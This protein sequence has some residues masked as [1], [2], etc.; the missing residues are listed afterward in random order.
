MSRTPHTLSGR[1][2]RCAARSAPCTLSA[3]LEEEWLAD[4]HERTSGQSR[5]RFAL[6]C[7]WA[8]AVIGHEHRP[9]AVPVASAAQANVVT[10][11]QT[12]LISS[13]A[14]TFGLVVCLHAAVF[15]GLILAGMN[16]R[17]F[18]PAE[19][20]ALLPRVIVVPQTKVTPTPPG[21]DWSF[22][23]DI[24]MP[25]ITDVLPPDPKVA[26]EGVTLGPD[27][28]KPPAAQPSLPPEVI[29]VQ[30]GAG[31][32]FPHP[33]EYYPDAAIRREEQGAAT[34]RVCVDPAGRLTSDPVTEESSGSD[35]L[36][37]AAI[38]LAKAGSGH[39][40]PS[41]DDGRPVNSCYPVKIRFQLKR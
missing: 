30:G 37:S 10:L 21:I 18:K 15:Y 29:H 12:P 2:V 39:Y 8:S 38:R 5:L 16:S 19:P 6:G 40:R 27:P 4:L 11:I 17:L 31:A 34:L 9:L 36:D 22:I 13:R 23:H 14:V 26:P 1:L 32:G 7:F 33:D 20:A 41:T 25:P 35:R 28:F 24:R 3:R